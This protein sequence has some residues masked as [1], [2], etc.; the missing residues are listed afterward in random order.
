[1][2]ASLRFS[3]FL[4]LVVGEDRPRRHDLQRFRG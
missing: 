3:L 2:Q 4:F 1:M